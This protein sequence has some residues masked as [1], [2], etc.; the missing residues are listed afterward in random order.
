MP[1]EGVK[2]FAAVLSL[3][4]ETRGANCCDWRAIARAA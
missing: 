4:Q 1:R 2:L 3:A